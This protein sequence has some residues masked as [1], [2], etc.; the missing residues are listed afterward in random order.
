MR[1]HGQTLRALPRPCP[2][3]VAAMHTL[4]CLVVG[5]YDVAGDEGPLHKC[6]DQSGECAGGTTAAEYEQL[7]GGSVVPGLPSIVQ[8]FHW[9]SSC[10]VCET[11]C[12][13]D[14]PCPCQCQIGRMKSL[15]LAS[16]SADGDTP[17]H[18]HVGLEGRIR[19]T[20][21]TVGDFVRDG[22]GRAGCHHEWVPALRGR[23]VPGAV[24]SGL[25]TLRADCAGCR[26]SDSG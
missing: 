5:K 20:Q 14:H 16:L 22:R 8:G 21:R 1:K 4:F 26:H 13:H 11:T 15:F 18:L 2:W 17:E 10:H 23:D 24:G 9:L 3:V 6:W 19:G 7:H 12:H 25:P